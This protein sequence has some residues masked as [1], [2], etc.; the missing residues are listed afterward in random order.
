MNYYTGLNDK[1]ISL[2]LSKE[3][4]F[5]CLGFYS[6]N[7]NDNIIYPDEWT[8]PFSA[9]GNLISQNSSNFYFTGSGFFDGNSLIKIDRP[10]E[11]NNSG[12]FLSYQRIRSAD[13]ILFSSITGDSFNNYSGYLLGVN[14][15]NKLYFKYWNPIEGPFTFTFKNII[16]DKNLIYVYK[17][18][19]S[20]T[21]GKYN[22][23]SFDF[24]TETFQILNNAFQDSNQLILGGTTLINKNIGWIN[25]NNFSGYIDK[26][27]ILKDISPFY[28]NDLGTSLFSN[29]EIVNINTNISCYQTG[30]SIL[31]GFSYTGITGVFVSGFTIETT[32]ITGYIDILSGFSYIGITGIE[33]TLIGS[34]VDNCGI[35]NNI[36]NSQSLTGLITGNLTI[37][38]GIIGTIFTTGAENINLTGLFT[39]ESLVTITG[40]VCVTGQETNL[41]LDYN[42]DYNFLKSLS[43]SE[44]SLLKNN[45]INNDILEIYTEKYTGIKLN[46]NQDLE[47]NSVDQYYYNNNYN[48]IDIL[49][50]KNGQTLIP[51]GISTTQSGYNLIFNPIV[52]YYITGNQIYVKNFN[53][54]DYVFYDVITGNFLAKLNTGSTVEIPNIMI[55]N[56]W[57]FKN[58]QKLISGKDYI[59]NLNTL[60][61]SDVSSSEEN[62]ILFK[63]IPNNFIYKSGN[64]GSLGL[65]DSFNHNSSQVYYNGI[66]QKLFN[67]YIENSKFDQI[68]G[69]FYNNFINNQILTSNDGFFITI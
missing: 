66:K 53:E 63:K 24:E 45:I 58:G 18:Q 56:Y 25:S 5:T 64:L 12:I 35:V 36:Y 2:W 57:I 43:Y 31:S 49:I 47:K 30:F 38:S 7:K 51:S 65:T 39:G 52:D 67:N 27:Y 21:I 9:S 33:Q 6:G 60:I 29:S 22:N 62:Y 55:D 32:G 48:D 69:N 61:L 16:S 41:I 11:I 59:K 50:F 40:E 46:Y 54:D 15:A 8:F 28:I 4:I 17:E 19:S 1:L 13:E 10:F 68:S 34:Y 44:V 3:N 42:K 37:S 23:N 20:V 14:E 26:F